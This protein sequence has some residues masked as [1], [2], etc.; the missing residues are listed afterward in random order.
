MPLISPST[1]A[2]RRRPYGFTLTELLLASVTTSIALFAL[3]SVYLLAF[4]MYRAGSAQTWQQQR[5]N[6]VMERLCEITR[7]A[8]AMKLYLNY[9]ANPAATN[10]GN[11]LFACGKGWSSAVYRTDTTLYYVPKT[12]TDNRSTSADDVP[13][14]TSLS[15][16]TTFFYTDTYVRITLAFMDPRAPSNELIRAT[17]SLSPRNMRWKL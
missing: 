17:T 5:M 4:R 9:S 8:S 11:Y 16:F 15:A 6:E 2:P 14:A 3:L 12:W 7:P 13:L 1:D 10:F